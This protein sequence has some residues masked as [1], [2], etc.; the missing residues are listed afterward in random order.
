MK[1]IINDFEVSDRDSFVKFIELLHDDLLN[2]PNKWENK[3]LP[4][5]LESFAR[6]AEEIQG[7]YNNT[8]QNVDADKPDWKTFSEIFKGARI[9]E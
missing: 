6:Y 4:D 1:D 2:N 8:N 7:Y 5:F 3:T 9:Y